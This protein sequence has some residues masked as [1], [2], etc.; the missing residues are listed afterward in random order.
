M[1]QNVLRLLAA[2]AAFSVGAGVWAQPVKNYPNKP[3]R[4]IVPYPPG[5]ANDNLARPLVQKISEGL[6]TQV[7]L[8]NRGSGGAMI[9]AN[10]VAKAAADG[11]TLLFCSTATHA[12]SPQLFSRVPYDPFKD[13]E[14]ITLLDVRGGR[15]GRQLA[16]RVCGL[17]PQ[18]I[19]KVR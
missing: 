4:L 13:F 15:S 12:T 6:G 18:R 16:A 14:P 9:G 8:D 7:V 11:Y 5:G 1:T 2:I 19:R 10:L 17:Y 3:I